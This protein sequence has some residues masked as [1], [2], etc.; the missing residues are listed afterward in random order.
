VPSDEPVTVDAMKRTILLLGLGLAAVACGGGGP[1]G[2]GGIQSSPNAI[3]LQQVQSAVFTPNCARSECHV[4]GSAPFGLELSEGE[5]FGNTVGV[6]SAEQP[7]FDRIE[8]GNPDDSYVFMK[9]TADFRISGDP[10]PP[11]GLAPGLTSTQIELLRDWIEQGAN[12]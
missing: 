6:A 2:T 4:A 11:V 8:P 12:P 5:T 9:V 7:G 10:M 3:T 1:D